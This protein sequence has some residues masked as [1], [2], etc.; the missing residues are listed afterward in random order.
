MEAKESTSLAIGSKRNV[1]ALLFKKRIIWLK[2]VLKSMKH[3]DESNVS[4]NLIGLWDAKEASLCFRDS[5]SHFFYFL[6]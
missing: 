1:P 3:R 4:G 6:K 2:L 5:A